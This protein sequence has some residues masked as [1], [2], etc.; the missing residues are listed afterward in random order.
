M[1]ALF[2]QCF[3]N[4]LRWGWWFCSSIQQKSWHFKIFLQ[5]SKSQ[6]PNLSFTHQSLYFSSPWVSHILLKAVAEQTGLVFTKLMVRFIPKY[7]QTP[8]IFTAEHAFV[9]CLAE[10]FCWNPFYLCIAN[11]CQDF[12]LCF[13]NPLIPKTQINLSLQDDT[14]FNISISFVSKK[15]GLRFIY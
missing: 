14:P 7:R 4:Y 11:L 6:K 10:N 8:W 9:Q 13:I 1:G 5:R 12:I 2:S 3:V 15:N